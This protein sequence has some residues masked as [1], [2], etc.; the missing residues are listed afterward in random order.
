M[1]RQRWR[2]SPR[3]SNRLPELLDRHFG[4]C[5]APSLGASQAV[6][7]SYQ[8]VLVSADSQFP[9]CALTDPSVDDGQGFENRV[10]RRKS[11][12]RI[13]VEI[14]PERVTNIVVVMYLTA[15]EDVARFPVFYS[16]VPPQREPFHLV[17]RVVRAEHLQ[18]VHHDPDLS[19]CV[20]TGADCLR[21][22]IVV[23]TM[24]S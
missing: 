11:F 14:S 18:A 24:L 4:G 19:R 13:H 5:T 2:S 7:H 16:M 9:Q 22:L 17:F 10:L 21:S 20:A 15:R 6:E 8:R 1:L 12:M 23:R 3:F